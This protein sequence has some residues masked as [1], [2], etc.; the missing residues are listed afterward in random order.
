MSE[1]ILVVGSYN[2]G[3]T[4]VAPTIPRPG[5]TVLGSGF[6]MGPGGKGSNQAIGIRRL[7]G[8]V[9]FVCRVGDDLFGAEAQELFARE[10]L[11]VRAEV[12]PGAATGAG[13]I[14]V[15]SGGQNAIAVAPGANARLAPA[16][17][18]PE[19][20]DGVGFLLLQLECALELAT[21]AGRLA[22]DHGVRVVLNPAP[23]SPLPEE[24]LDLVDVLTPNETELE[25]ISGRPAGS[26]EEALAAAEAVRRPGRH[27][28]VTR[29]AEGAL[30]VSDGGA[31]DVPGVRVDGVVD[32]TGAGDAFNA[33][34]VTGLAEGMGFEDAIALGNR[35]GAYCVTREGV[36]DGLPTR[37]ELEVFAG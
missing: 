28:V 34:L 19:W 26:R 8:D 24:L 33:G 2:V 30:W 1:A 37:D 20:F 9:R 22:R 32:T 16:D 36:I 15:D 13:L 6:H 11:D 5:E 35:C 10:G 25:T 21:S 17:L 14:V 4:V 18:L 23:G 27:V 7:G 31:V 12:D 3:L 29:G